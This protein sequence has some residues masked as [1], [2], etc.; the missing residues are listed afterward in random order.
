MPQSTTSEFSSDDSAASSDTFASSSDDL[1]D[2]MHEWFVV[3]F[4]KI[5]NKFFDNY[6]DFTTTLIDIYKHHSFGVTIMYSTGA[7]GKRTR[8]IFAYNCVSNRQHFRSHG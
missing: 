3:M 8:V 7:G 2:P 5:E 4:D 1:F 6:N